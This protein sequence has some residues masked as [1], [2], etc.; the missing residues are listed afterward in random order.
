[1]IKILSAFEANIY[2]LKILFL[3]FWRQKMILWGNL[4]FVFPTL[5]CHSELVSESYQLGV[6]TKF[7]QDPETSSGWQHAYF[8]TAKL[9]KKIHLPKCSKHTTFVRPWNKFSMTPRLFLSDQMSWKKVVGLHYYANKNFIADLVK[10]TYF[11]L[12]L[13]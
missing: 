13:L 4:K 3:E 2:S 9:L 11:F 6:F 5:K 12:Y 8:L 1:M 10:P 7:W